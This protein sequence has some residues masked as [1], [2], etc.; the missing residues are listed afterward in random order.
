M[1]ALRRAAGVTALLALTFLPAGCST[2]GSPGC[3][4]GSGVRVFTAASESMAPTIKANTRFLV[5]TAYYQGHAVMRGDIVILKVPPSVSSLAP[6]VTDVVKRVI[7]LPGETISSSPSGQVLINGTAISEPWLPTNDALGPYIAQ[8]TIPSGQYYVLGDNRSN[9]E[10]SRFWG[11]VSRSL[12]IGRVETNH[13]AV[14][15]P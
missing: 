3:P 11:P 4:G 15:Q 12:L 14:C 8:T 6:N 10:D 1:I 9:S 5:D 7:G 2:L 13:G